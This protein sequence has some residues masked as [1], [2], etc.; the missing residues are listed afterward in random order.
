MISRKPML[1]AATL[2]TGLAGAASLLATSAIAQQDRML[3][4]PQ[5]A[6]A[7]IYRDAYFAGP[8]VYVDGNRPDMGLAWP[9]NSIRVEAGRWQLCEKTRFRGT[10]RTYDVTTAQLTFRGGH[11][12]Q[13]IRLLGGGGGGG[14][15]I[16]PVVPGPN[17]SL[18]GMAAQFYAAPAANGLRV[19]ACQTGN[20]TA[21][22]AATTADRFCV[23]NGW[24]GSAREAMETVAR[25]EYLVDVLCT[26]TGR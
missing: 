25:R 11:K 2:A 10:C 5:Q 6:S 16:G 1:L 3:R 18:R 15:G 8:A 17:P 7:T 9:V 20:A 13:S 23:Q 14:G 4:P 21:K 26:R 19:L 22:C 12:V 24:T